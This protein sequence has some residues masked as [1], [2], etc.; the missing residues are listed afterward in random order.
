ML[1]L[2]ELRHIP[3]WS[4][5][6]RNGSVPRTVTKILRGILM[7][8]LRHMGPAMLV[9]SAS[10]YISTV[11]NNPGST[12]ICPRGISFAKWTPWLQWI[13]LLLDCLILTKIRNLL[14][15]WQEK[16]TE[17]SSAGASILGAVFLVRLQVT[18]RAM[19]WLM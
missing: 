4:S 18:T 17:R 2:V 13:S 10:V 3:L 7:S 5:G 8:I 9:S 15:L 16:K 19:S 12:F 1:A 14:S 6:E 11:V